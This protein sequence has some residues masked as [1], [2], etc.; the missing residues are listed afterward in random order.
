MLKIS[1][2][3]A[4]NSAVNDVGSRPDSARKIIMSQWAILPLIN[5]GYFW[6]R[7][8]CA[9]GPTHV[10]GFQAVCAERVDASGDVSCRLTTHT[11][12]TSGLPGFDDRIAEC[13]HVNMYSRL[14]NVVPRRLASSRNEYVSDISATS[15][16]ADGTERIVAKQHLSSSIEQLNA[17]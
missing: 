12:G 10:F 16:V 2:R 6:G 1:S 15:R 7:D 13:F 5:V 3:S 14:C 4:Q 9:A 11:A 17:K 8:Q